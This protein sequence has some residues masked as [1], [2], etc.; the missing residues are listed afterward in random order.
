LGN[1]LTAEPLS[2]QSLRREDQKSDRLLNAGLPTP[3]ND[4]IIG[5][6]AWGKVILRL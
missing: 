1:L 2:T 3:S 5:R 6:K 4:S